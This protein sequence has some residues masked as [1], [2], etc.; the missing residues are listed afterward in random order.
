[1]MTALLLLGGLATLTLGGEFLVRGASRLALVMR[2]SPLVIGLTVV[3]MGTSAPEMAVSVIASI[4]GK[5]DISLGNVVGSNIFNVL[6]ILGISALVVPL[7]VNPQLLRFDVPVMIAVSAVVL[8]FGLDGR[9]APWEGWLLFAGLV[10]YTL[11]LLR[12]SRKAWVGQ[13]VPVPNA[14]HWAVNVALVLAGLGLLVLGSNWFVDGSVRVARALGM[15]ELMIG[16]TIV[17]VGTSMPELAT[18]IVAAARGQRDIAVGNVVGSNVFNL[19]G[20]L[21]ISAGISRTGVA[22]SGTALAFDIPVMIAIAVACLPVFYTGRKVARVEGFFFLVA[23]AA[24]TAYLVLENL[25]RPVLTAPQAIWWVVAPATGISLFL[26]TAA[27][28]RE[29]SARI[30]AS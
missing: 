27:W 6:G 5:A 10:G 4:E 8:L 9:I 21:G 2:I 3:A 26:G 12:M 23:Y 14:G 7:A 1:M 24:Y 19:L 30:P 22:V 29:R 25:E 18:S 15:S 17:A 16:L 28:M 13:P 11:A 20:V